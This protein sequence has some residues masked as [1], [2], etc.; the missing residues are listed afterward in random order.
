MP[1]EKGTLNEYFEWLQCKFGRALKDNIDFCFF[2]LSQHDKE[3]VYQ[4][5]MQAFLEKC[6]KTQ[7]MRRDDGVGAYLKGI[8]SNKG[9]DLCKTKERKRVDGDNVDVKKLPASEES[10]C[11][12]TDPLERQELARLI[13]EASDTLEPE[14]QHI[15]ET[16]CR[17]YPESTM[18]TKL[19]NFAGM[20]KKQ[21]W[22]AHALCKRARKKIIRYLKD[23]GYEF[24]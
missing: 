6:K 5:T 1:D 10:S 23:K 9:Y 8:A 18:H 11:F 2:G 24:D 12:L 20:P 13:V 19:A 17:H 15:W 3:D 14:E 21:A 16:Y 7:K 22:K 4:K